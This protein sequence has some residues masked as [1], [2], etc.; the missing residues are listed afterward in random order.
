M[1]KSELFKAAH[2]LAKAYQLKMG[3]D[4]AVY[5]SVALKN[6]NGAIKEGFQDEML[7]KAMNF[8]I[9]E[10]SNKLALISRTVKKTFYTRQKRIFT[11][12]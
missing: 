10:V 7:F 12:L 2:K 8:K 3:G 9:K 11:Y 5:L 4:Y 6:L 1:T